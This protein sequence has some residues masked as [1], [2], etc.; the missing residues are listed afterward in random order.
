MTTHIAFGPFE[1]DPERATLLRNGE[2]VTIGH[3]AATLLAALVEAEGSTVPKSDLMERVWPG[4]IV[5]EGNLTVQIA[6]L[7]K[8]MGAMPDGQSWILTVPREGYRLLAG[9]AGGPHPTAPVLAVLPFRAVGGEAEADYFADGVVEDIV[10]ALSRFRS[11]TV[12]TT[13]TSFAHRDRTGDI[14]EIAR[15]LGVR[16]ALQGSVRRADDRLRITAQLVEGATGAP[17]WAEHFD[18]A[19]ADV[20]EF[21]DR[22]TADVAM[23]VEPRIQ[24]AEIERSRRERPGSIAAY[25]AY[26]QAVPKINKETA[27][28]NAE[29]YRLLRQALAIEPDNALLLAHAAWALS[30]RYAMGWPPIGDDDVQT[31]L[32]LSRR[33]L[34]RAAGD[35]V[36]LAHCGMNLIHTAKNYD[37]GM[38]V[39]DMA[40]KANPNNHM[41]VVSAGV[42]H[43]HCGTI[44]D[45]LALFQRAIR[46][47]P[48]DPLAHVPFSGIAHCHMVHGDYAEALAWAVRS[49]S[50]NTRFDPTYWMLIAAN[51]HLG[52]MAEARRFLQDL[53]ALAPEV[54]VA[55]IRAGQPAK[56]PAR[57]ATIL[58]GLRLAGLPEG[59][60]GRA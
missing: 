23:V 1:L 42:A 21:Q 43:L 45:S 39:L 3:R 36:V 40:A 49:L 35:P 30:H 46:L 10:T 27:K 32:E 15:E 57:V 41:V 33:A 14:R 2:P 58:E 50:L 34:Q 19:L 13:G 16:Y 52:H 4:T 7:R 24:I 54:T 9:T 28:E 20:F 5:E 17:L 6:A 47:S 59:A 44:E 8:A 25:D 18:G 22:I 60:E 31:C 11:F 12:L 48:N 37:L 38:A 56:D 55:S 53:R 26:L 29:A 51:A